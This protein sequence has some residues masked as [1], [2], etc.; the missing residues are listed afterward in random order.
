MMKR[1][2]TI[3]Q[4]AQRGK[5]QMVVDILREIVTESDNRTHNIHKHLALIS[6]V[7]GL[8]L[9]IYV[10][11][12][13]QQFDIQ[14]FGIGVGALLTGTGAALRLSQE[15]PSPERAVT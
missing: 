3:Q 14:T 13:G 2:G 12:K 6:V 5:D 7:V 4:S 10:V 1:T 9:E 15:S 8:S 11:V